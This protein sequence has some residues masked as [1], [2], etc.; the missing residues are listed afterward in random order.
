MKNL[1]LEFAFG[2]LFLLL[3]AP[4]YAQGSTSGGGGRDEARIFE[5]HDDNVVEVANDIYDYMFEDCN[6]RDTPPV[7]TIIAFLSIPLHAAAFGYDEFGS[8]TPGLRVLRG[9]PDY[10]FYFDN[11]NEESSADFLYIGLLGYQGSVYTDSTLLFGQHIFSGGSFTSSNLYKHIILVGALRRSCTG[12]P[13][14]QCI[15]NMEILIIDKNIL[16]PN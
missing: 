6:L 2:T 14:D 16:G 15:G 9:T 5:L 3:S 4:L 7:D 12:H 13:G 1:M 11:L 10:D 8:P